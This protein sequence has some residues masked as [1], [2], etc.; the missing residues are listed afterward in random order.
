MDQDAVKDPTGYWTKQRMKKLS[1]GDRIRHESA[2]GSGIG[3]N[4]A[5][6]LDRDS[7]YP[8]NVVH[9]PAECSNREHH[10]AFPETLPSWFIRLFSKP[11]DVVLDPF[12][13]SGTTAAAA[14]QLGRAYVGVEIS[15]E[16]KRIAEKRLRQE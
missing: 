5:N 7:V 14:K 2:T 4:L 6:W 8:D 13:G 15:A 3:R 9:L 1:A 11:G 16:N 10:S 12:V